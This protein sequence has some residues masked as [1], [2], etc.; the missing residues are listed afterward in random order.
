MRV[1]AGLL[2]TA[3]AI[4]LALTA[5]NKKAGVAARLSE[6]EQAFQAAARGAPAQTARVDLAQPLPAEAHTYLNVALSAI[7]T[8]NYALG[9][10]ALEAVQRTPKVTAA[11][12]MAV[13]GLKEAV[14]A[15]LVERAGRGDPTAK[16]ALAA[17]EKTRSQ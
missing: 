9:V 15:D 13:Q 11:Q 6:V 14:T 8:N 1:P 12:L 5:C 7:R 2:A 10:M 4:L 3:A 17:I 16:A